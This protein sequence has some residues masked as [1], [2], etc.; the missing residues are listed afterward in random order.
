MKYTEVF[1]K[2]G[3]ILSSPRQDWS[4]ENTNG[5]C[6]SLWTHQLTKKDDRLVYDTR[7]NSGPD[8][9]WINKS[10]NKKRIKH[11][12]LSLSKFGG[13]I[14]AICVTGNH[15]NVESASPW[16]CS[17]RDNHKWKIVEFE[18]DIGHFRAEAFPWKP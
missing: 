15:G 10:G 17:S 2:L 14:D 6:I 8:E 9:L 18:A 11:I 13:W 12:D 5:V 16:I 3:Y 1:Q 4:A 7:V